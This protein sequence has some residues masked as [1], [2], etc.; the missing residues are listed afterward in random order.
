MMY[1]CSEM[2]HCQT[3]NLCLPPP[4][5]PH[6]LFKF[7]NCHVLTSV[8]SLLH[9]SHQRSEDWVKC[10]GEG[11]VNDATVHVC[12]EVQFTDIIVL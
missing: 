1:Q 11:T 10:N 6:P 5:P 8:G 9:S 4:L 2:N 7:Q 3:S 12:P